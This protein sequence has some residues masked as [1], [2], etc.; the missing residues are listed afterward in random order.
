LTAMTAWRAP[1]GLEWKFPE[2][3]LVQRWPIKGVACGQ[4]IAVVNAH[5]MTS[6]Y[7]CAITACPD[8]FGCTWSSAQSSG[9]VLAR[10]ALNAC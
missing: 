9:R 2:D 4:P 3:L 1:L 6:K 8:R 10:T 5:P 7:A